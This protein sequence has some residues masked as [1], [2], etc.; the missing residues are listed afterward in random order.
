MTEKEE[1]RD[2]Q[3]WDSV[4]LRGWGDREK[5]AKETKYEWPERQEENQTSVFWKPEEESISRMSKWPSAE[6]A[7]ERCRKMKMPWF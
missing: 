2:R 4:T 3:T 6:Y 1:K 5:Q 7:A